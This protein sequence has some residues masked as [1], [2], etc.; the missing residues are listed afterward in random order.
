LWSEPEVVIVKDSSGRTSRFFEDCH[1]ASSQEARRSELDSTA[2]AGALGQSRLPRVEVAFPILKVKIGSNYSFA[3]TEGT[4]V[5][6]EEDPV[7]DEDVDDE[8]YCDDSTVEPGDVPVHRD[9]IRP[10]AG[11]EVGETIIHHRA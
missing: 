5:E 8:G 1:S 7:G 4:F 9:R 11:E 10:D 6:Q 3:T 2:G